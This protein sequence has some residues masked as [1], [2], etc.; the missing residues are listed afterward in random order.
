MDT[1]VRPLTSDDMDA[2]V[3]VLARGMRDNPNHIAVWG[4]DLDYRVTALT[5]FM[6]ATLPLASQPVCA[7]RDGELVGVCGIA[8]PGE[9]IGDIFRALGGEVPQFSEVADEQ[10]RIAE[11]LTAWGTR[12]LAEPHW[13]LGPLAADLPVQRQGIG[14]VLMDRFCGIV[15]AAGDVAYLET[16][17]PENVG[18]YERFS[19]ETIGE[20][21]VLGVHNWF[22]RR[23]AQ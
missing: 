1:E 12:D 2:G 20:V 18:F 14:T 5:S 17:K 13:H 3:G 4:D 7:V 11:W 9:C 10:E 8:P 21:D 16:D 22:M 6:G 19:F 15:D 23:A